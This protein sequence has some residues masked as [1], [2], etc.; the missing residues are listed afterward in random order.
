MTIVNT[1]LGKVEGYTK[2]GISTFKGIP[3]AKPPVGELRFRA[4]QPAEPWS[5]N[6][7]AT[8]FR[9][10]APQDANPIMQVGEQSEDCL[11]LNIWTPAADNKKR[12]VLFWIHGGGFF[13]GSGAQREY[14]GAGMAS[15]GDVVVV[16]INYRLGALGFTYFNDLIGDAH[17]TDSNLGIRDQV[18]ALQW[19]QENIAQFGGDPDNITIFGESAGAMSVGTLLGTPDANGLFHKAIPQSGAGHTCLTTDCATNVAAKFLEVLSI[20]PVK[21]EKLWQVSTKEILDAQRKCAG[22]RLK[23]GPWQLPGIGMS[24]IPVVEDNYLPDHPYEMVKQGSAKDVDLMIGT[25]RDEWNLFAQLAKMAPPEQAQKLGTL[26][27]NVTEDNIAQIFEQ[28]LPGL[29][30]SALAFYRDEIGAETEPLDLFVALE[31]DCSFTI[32]AIRMAEEQQKHRANTYMYRFDWQSPM[33]GACHAIDIPFVFG[34][35]NSPFGT[36]LTGGGEKAEDLSKQVQAAWINFA[37]TGD[38]NHADLPSWPTYCDSQRSTMI[39]DSEN[40]VETNPREEARNFFI[41]VA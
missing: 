14:S 15:E 40:S 3:F 30:E 33:L 32:P 38:P 17:P 20:D 35:I 7:D 36:M 4:P 2:N 34:G 28:R 31:T 39:F 11:Y 16:T 41:Q 37:K 6:L 22:T 29:G 12:P 26:G 8:K 10:A 24:F 5:G 19:V 18:A 25:T 21:P 13:I 9:T 1:S 23:Y 27:A